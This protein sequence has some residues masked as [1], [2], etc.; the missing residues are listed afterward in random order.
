MKT[1]RLFGAPRS[2]RLLAW[3]TAATLLSGS[4]AQ[5][6]TTDIQVWYSLNPYN[7]QVFEKLVKQYNG[8]QKD[9]KVTLKGFDNAD[10]IEPALAAGAKSKNIPNLVQLENNQSPD[11]IAKLSYIL[12]LHTLLSKHPIKEAKWFVSSDNA[13]MRDGKGRLMAFPYMVD[14]PVMYYNVDA[15][16]KAGIEP[17]APARS[18]Q[19][20]QDQLVKLANGGSRQCPLTTDQSVS[21]NL[22]NLAAINNQ[23][24]TSGDNGLKTAKAAPAF[25]FDTLYIRHLSMMIS[26]VRTE[27]MLKPGGEAKSAERFANREC[28][29]FMSTSSDL[30]WFKNSRSLNFGMSGLPY[31]PQVT[32]KPGNP[33][34]GGGALWATDGHTPTQNKATADF[35]S[36]LA[37][38][39][40]A[41]AWYQETGYLPLTQQAFGMTDKAYYKNLGDWQNLVAVYANQPVITGRGFKISNYPKIKAMFR[42][43]LDRA[44]NGQE[45]AVTALG[46]ASTEASKIMRER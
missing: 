33:F 8:D 6:A 16:K 21:V 36:W 35:L 10:A 11:D 30:G 5:A 44:L 13:F 3:A 46:S 43:T 38:P 45:P 9:V 1:H 29:V 7:K 25:S 27:L 31:Y 37:Q 20:L 18:W 17:A 32:Q 4:L 42:K 19:G 23:M 12:P 41:A 26:W 24:Y 40:N 22:E 28:A 2:W 39:K 14:I 15:F 34:V